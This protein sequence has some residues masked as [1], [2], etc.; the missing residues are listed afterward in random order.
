MRV[1]QYVDSLKPTELSFVDTQ[2]DPN[3]EVKLDI[4]TVEL[5]FQ[6]STRLTK[7]QKALVKDAIYL[8]AKTIAYNSSVMKD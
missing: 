3:G 7:Q 5:P 8:Q 4:R 2:S 1:K 6:I